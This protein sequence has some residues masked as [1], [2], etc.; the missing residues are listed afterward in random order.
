M[1]ADSWKNERV[2]ITGGA[3]FIGSNLA[4]RLVQ[5]GASVRIADNLER[6]REEYIAAIADRVEVLCGGS[7]R[8][9]RL[10][11]RVPEYGRRLPPRFAGWRHRFL[12]GAARRSDQAQLRHRPEYVRSGPAS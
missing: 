11:D 7:A 12:F 10:P 9:G 3:G 8:E 6:G 1:T 4:E 2:L 5:D